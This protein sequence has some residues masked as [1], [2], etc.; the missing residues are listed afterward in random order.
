M[1][2]RISAERQQQQQQQQ[3]SQSAT[4]P[5]YRTG[6]QPPVVQVQYISAFRLFTK[7]SMT[8]IERRIQEEKRAR[9]NLQRQ[10]QDGGAKVAGN[11]S[12]EDKLE[13]NPLLAAGNKLPAKLGDFPPELYGKPIEDVDEF[14]QNQYVSMSERSMH[15]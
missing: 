14:Y 9:E 3:Q 2:K 7:E 8:K 1:E 11:D 4:Q 15:A 12:T 13:P 10:D 5:P 6:S